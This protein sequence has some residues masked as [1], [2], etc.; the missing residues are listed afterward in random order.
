MAEVIS[1]I[2][3]TVNRWRSSILGSSWWGFLTV[4]LRTGAVRLGEAMPQESGLCLV[5]NRT[6]FEEQRVGR[7]AGNSPFRAVVF[8]RHSSDWRASMGI[9]GFLPMVYGTTP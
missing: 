9:R 4:L 3:G 6:T 2:V 7:F 5:T 1:R 8:R